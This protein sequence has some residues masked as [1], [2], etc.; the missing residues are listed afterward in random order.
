MTLKTSAASRIARV[1]RERHMRS[2]PD[3]PRGRDFP[4]IVTS[5]VNLSGPMRARDL[6]AV[7]DSQASEPRAGFRMAQSSYGSYPS[8]AQVIQ[9]KERSFFRRSL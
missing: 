3:V 5:A 1:R 2:R 7:P 4:K 8:F 9:L 6:A